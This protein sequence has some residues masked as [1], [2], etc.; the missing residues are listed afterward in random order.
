MR[1]TKATDHPRLAILQLQEE[2]QEVHEDREAYLVHQALRAL[3]DYQEQTPSKASLADQVLEAPRVHQGRRDRQA[4]LDHRILRT[5]QLDLQRNRD[6]PALT[7]RKESL[8][9]ISLH[10]TELRQPLTNG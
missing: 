10:L 7:S 6:R 8:Q 2:Y 1:M 4:P 3:Q 5:Q 9:R